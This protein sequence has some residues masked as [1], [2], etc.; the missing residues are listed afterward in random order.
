MTNFTFRCIF[1]ICV[2]LFLANTNVRSQEMTQLESMPNDVKS[3]GENNLF[4][5]GFRVNGSSSIELMLANNEK[6]DPTT[7]GQS[8]FQ[9]YRKNDNALTAIKDGDLSNPAAVTLE[10]SGDYIIQHWVKTNDGDVI[11]SFDDFDAQV[12]L[13][14][15]NGDPCVA[16]IRL[17]TTGLEGTRIIIGALPLDW[18]IGE[19]YELW[20]IRRPVGV[21]TVPVTVIPP[22]GIPYTVQMNVTQI[23]AGIYVGNEAC[24]MTNLAGQP[25][26]L[27]PGQPL[28]PAGTTG[29]ET[30]NIR[31]QLD[32][33]I[34]YTF[35]NSRVCMHENSAIRYTS[36]FTMSSNQVFDRRRPDQS[37]YGAWN[38]IIGADVGSLV[39][40]ANTFQGA[41]SALAARG[42]TNSYALTGN[43]FVRNFIGIR[44]QARNVITTFTNN[45]FI[46]DQS[47]PVPTGGT[48]CGFT[49]Q[50]PKP[51]GAFMF[52]GV[53]VEPN[54][55]FNLPA[56]S[57]G[58]T[59]VG[60]ANGV[61]LQDAS[62]I[63]QGCSFTNMLN[64]VY[65]QG[66]G[67]DDG[68]GVVQFAVG[69]R[70]LTV[71]G[72]GR[73][74]AT[75]F[76]GCRTAIL[77]ENTG[78]D[79][80]NVSNCLI[81]GV[82]EGISLSGA[83]SFTN[84][85]ITN[86]TIR[87]FSQFGIECRKLGLATNLN[88][89][90]LRAEGGS[91]ARHCIGIFNSG[92]LIANTGQFVSI[93]GNRLSGGNGLLRA[94]RG[95]FIENAGNVAVLDNDLQNQSLA[96]V[97]VRG[98]RFNQINCNNASRTTG[99]AGF[100]SALWSV[101]SAG[102]AWQNNITGRHT[103]GLRMEGASNP[104]PI[105]CNT[106]GQAQVGVDYTAMASNSVQ[107]VPTG[108]NTFQSHG[109]A[110]PG[111][112]SQWA[113]NGIG[114]AGTIVSNRFHILTSELPNFATV[115]TPA[116]WFSNQ[117]TVGTIG[118]PTNT[119]NQMAIEDDRELSADDR[120][121]MAGNGAY[122]DLTSYLDLKNLY[123]DARQ[124]VELQTDGDA[125]AFIQGKSTTNYG[126]LTNVASQLTDL[127][128]YESD[129]LS[130]L[131]AQATQLY[132]E[133]DA[134]NTALESG[135]STVDA[136]LTQRNTLDDQLA[137]VQA[138][139]ENAKQQSLATKLGAK[140]NL[141][142]QLALVA[143]Q[144]DF[145]AADKQI[146]ELYIQT[147]FVGVPLST[148]EKISLFALAQMCEHT[149]G[150]AVL[151]AR[152]WYL[153]ETG[154]LIEGSCDGQT[155]ERSTGLQPYK[156]Q[157]LNT[158]TISPNPAPQSFTLSLS[159]LPTA[160]C[161]VQIMNPLGQIVK[162]LSVQAGNEKLEVSN[163]QLPVGVYKLIVYEQE[164]PSAQATLHI[165]E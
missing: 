35:E 65:G 86:N 143:P 61:F 124:T 57:V 105:R 144:S 152:A 129:A 157:M 37:S 88:I 153:A 140:A 120:A 70:R 133:I 156:Y 74:A 7:I 63:V 154:E 2:S 62:A 19:C 82:I 109:N 83:G 97:D 28:F 158:V 76:T 159:W 27:L 93:V 73:T 95:V 94:Q 17:F 134:L 54:R 42:L 50:I 150:T 114:M 117:L 141:L 85:S 16:G 126:V 75:T 51:Q 69:A 29:G 79:V 67:A 40:N 131:N 91:N 20:N 43:T 121:K 112:F 45:R 31:G 148:S 137:L 23:P 108:I 98:G 78:T 138:A 55:S 60:I 147:S 9:V 119:C 10:A 125:V 49:N 164:V 11:E 53:Y 34:N 68:R 6:I 77:C 87:A 111:P 80:L 38:A 26:L 64:G 25:N 41:Y 1:L 81:S 122:S 155:G 165:A 107:G 104:S 135:A 13:E 18:R 145:D 4:V 142:S 46:T 47:Y 103:I 59:F 52:A 128:Q 36:I 58:N 71:I 113:A 160:D 8:K 123:A 56:S 90:N 110:W 89:N 66:G 127:E 161:T 14:S 132:I 163:V 96:G 116:G 22:N 39:A 100:S 139:V 72:L 101:L 44:L 12:Y 99:S 3:V 151:Q 32:I 136:Q 15:C 5:F 33:P 30:V 146:L 106:F 115:T 84:S 48:G 149:H 118:C 102:N 24:A 21:N 130:A 92:S 162:T